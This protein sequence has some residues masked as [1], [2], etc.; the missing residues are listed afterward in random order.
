MLVDYYNGLSRG[1]EKQNPYDSRRFKNQI[2]P[3][4]R[5][6]PRDVGRV[7]PVRDDVNPILMRNPERADPPANPA[8][9]NYRSEVMQ[10]DFLQAAEIIAEKKKQE[11]AVKYEGLRQNYNELLT[12]FDQSEELRK[13]Y[14]QLVVDQRS[15]IGKIRAQL[16]EQQ[17]KNATLEMNANTQGLLRQGNPTFSGR[18]QS[19]SPTRVDAQFQQNLNSGAGRPPNQ[20][21]GQMLSGSYGLGPQ[22]SGA[23]QDYGEQRRSIDGRA[24]GS[25]S[26]LGV[27]ANLALPGQRPPLQP[28]S[29]NNLQ[30]PRPNEVRYGNPGYKPQQYG[31]REN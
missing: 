31:N 16:A 7:R 6:A 26:L 20:L 21:Y 24:G 18:A 4:P 15:E 30:Q 2:D 3:T 28:P 19:Q 11:I 23:R 17:Q 13:V 12:S 9:H 5:E 27:G 8:A 10:Q 22:A 25:Q 1:Q 14:K 29:V